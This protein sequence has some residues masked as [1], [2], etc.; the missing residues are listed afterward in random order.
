MRYS[1]SNLAVAASSLLVKEVFA[2]RYDVR[3][4]GLYVVTD[5]VIVTEQV[6][7]YDFGTTLST[8]GARPIAT[9]TLDGTPVL[10]PAASSPS[11]PVSPSTPAAVFV[12]EP[13]KSS[14]P[15]PVPTTTTKE[16]VVVPATT[17]PVVVPTTLVPVKTSTPAPVSTPAGTT[18]SSSAKRGLAFNDASLLSGFAGSKAISWAYNWGSSGT[19][20]SPWE[21]V[22]LLWGLSATFT[23]GWNA[24]ATKA[25]A[26]GSTHLM[27][28]NEP[29][30]GSQSNL[31]P[32]EAA[33]GYKTY[34]MPFAGKAQLGSPAV[35]N[36]GSP[37]GLNWL[38]NFLTAC[39]DC[40][41]DFVCIHWYN[42][43]DAAAFMAYIDQAYA[44]GG[45]RP[46][47]VTEFQGEGDVTAQNAFL[48]TVIPQ[49][50]ASPKVA[51]YAYFMASDGNLLSSG[52][53]LSALGNTFAFAG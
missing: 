35:T 17:P 23:S 4:R 11:T 34:M 39:T 25:I 20:P 47:W 1:I 49:L 48:E 5:E 36:G 6:T 8:G 9:I 13:P 28:M 24:A 42:G 15:A 53:S 31:S 40:Q 50:D 37:M 21:Y 43:G 52:T 38:E 45:N 7:V 30:L 33:A 10:V 18:T 51:R 19:V 44:A 22:P 2:G 3:K 12:Q 41:I 29:D 16:A 32:A 26:A 27:S 46:L 14:T